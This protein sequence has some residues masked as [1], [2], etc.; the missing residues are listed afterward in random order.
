MTYPGDAFLYFFAAIVVVANNARMHLITG[1]LP[2]LLAHIY[3]FAVY[4]LTHHLQTSW[5]VGHK[6]NEGGFSAQ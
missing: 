1:Y 4:W 5:L 3:K 2:H 6:A